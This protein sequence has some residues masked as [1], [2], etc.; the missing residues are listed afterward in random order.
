MSTSET[1]G[2]PHRNGHVRQK[3]IAPRTNKESSLGSLMQETQALKELLRD[4]FTRSHRLL[5]A[6][7]RHNRQSRIVQ[8]TLAS[9]RQLHQI[10]A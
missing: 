1:N 7:K 9:L 4:G 3:A 8:S 2:T 5:A 10:D 6:L